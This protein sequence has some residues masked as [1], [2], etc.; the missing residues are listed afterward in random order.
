[1]QKLHRDEMSVRTVLVGTRRNT[2][3]TRGGRQLGDV[4]RPPKLFIL[5]GLVSSLSDD[6]ST[7]L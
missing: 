4:L 1:M 7:N 6:L 5:V 2:E 3:V